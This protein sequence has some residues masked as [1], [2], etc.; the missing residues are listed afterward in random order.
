[1]HRSVF[2]QTPHE[3]D[4]VLLESTV[5]SGSDGRLSTYTVSATVDGW[6]GNSTNTEDAPLACRRAAA[7]AATAAADA[8]PTL[9]GDRLR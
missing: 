7:A 6:R 1:M 8:P 9:G 2:D 3:L 5:P 4:E